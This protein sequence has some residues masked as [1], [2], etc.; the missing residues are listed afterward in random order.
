MNSQPNNALLSA[1]NHC[2]NACNFCSTA[3]LEEQDV[4]MMVNCIRLDTDCAAICNLTASLIARN[5]VHGKH[6]L[7][8]CA[9]ICGLC[10]AECEKHKKMQHCADCAAACRTC[11]Q[12]C[13]AAA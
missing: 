9:E 5:S 13:R 2:A 1:L 7:K 6:L 4:K 12:A 8:E 10:A 11:E 3:C